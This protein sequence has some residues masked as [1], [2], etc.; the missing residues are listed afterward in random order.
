[1]TYKK[2]VNSSKCIYRFNK[3][4][5]KI[6]IERFFSPSVLDKLIKIYGVEQKVKNSQDFP[7][8][9]KVMSGD[10]CPIIYQATLNTILLNWCKQTTVYWDRLH[11]PNRPISIWIYGREGMKDQRRKNELPI[12]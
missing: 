6:S 10:T 12:N 11:V 3:N 9:E 1:M 5:I 8:E 4:S 2:Y 7:A